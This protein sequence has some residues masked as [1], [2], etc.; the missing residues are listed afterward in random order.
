[1]PCATAIC[2]R[3]WAPAAV[4][5]AVIV[6]F[7]ASAVPG[8]VSLPY[9]DTKIALRVWNVIVG[10]VAVRPSQSVWLAWTVKT[11]VPSDGFAVHVPP[12][13]VIDAL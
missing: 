5:A 12:A 7:G 3:D 10:L 6:C 4:A 8:F 1:M 13:G 2:G 9:G 11:P